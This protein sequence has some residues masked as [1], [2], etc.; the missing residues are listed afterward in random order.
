MCG[1]AGVRSPGRAVDRAVLEAMLAQMHHRGPDG[2]GLWVDGEIGLGMRRLAIVDVAGGQQP[3]ANEDGTVKVVFNG[4]I[5]N[6]EE[7]RAL[8]RARGHT[9]TSDTDGEV[10]PHLY[11]EFGPGFVERLDGIFGFAVWDAPRETLMLARDQLGVKP[12]YFH[13]SGGSVRFASELKAL[14]ADPSVPRELDLG[15]LDEYLTFRFTPAPN[16]LLRG[17]EKL[18]PA[19]YAVFRGGEATKLR[20]WDPQPVERT[21]L[22]LEEAADEFRDLL[23][24]AVRRQMMSDRPI[25]A[26]L[27]G[28]I[29]SAAVV[30]L[31]AECS[32]KVKTFTVGFEGGGDAD[33]TGL[34]RQT[35][36]LFDT[37]HHDAIVQLSDFT[38]ELAGTIEL[39]EEPVG[40]SSALGFRQVARL[41]R[42]LVPVLLSGQGADELLAG[43]WRYVGEWIAGRT[44]GVVK[45]LH[46]ERP[47]AAAAARVKTAR[48]ERGLRALRQ[49]DTLTRFL[50]IYSVFSA[51]QKHL[52]YGSELRPLLALN[53]NGSPA[54]HVERYRSRAAGR[55]SLSQMMYVDTRLWLPDDL[56]LVG[57]KMSMAE[58]VEMRVP[59]LDRALVEFTESLPSRYKLRRGV[60]KLV[61][62]EALTGLLPREIVHRKERGF[63][64][65]VA[66]WLR[67]GLSAPARE[68]LLDPDGT[69]GS[70]MDRGY[71]AQILDDHRDGR[72]DYTRQLFSLYSLE[73]WARRFTRLE[74]VA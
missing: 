29:D 64:T 53:G 72:A 36:Q 70:L 63:V 52:L 13:R 38:E 73:L 35:A 25:G 60:R 21:D 17:V 24:Q 69:C 27:S 43:Y 9:F 20:Y 67:E 32:T 71:M 55:D 45:G 54:R 4:E 61:E 14:T 3:L 51:E 40:T 8:L 62:K 2:E 58:S 66:R 22:S 30:A 16:T 12:L 34:A 68:L 7:L 50:D 47:V 44:L 42:P 46:L 19:T 74:S 56:L 57:D 11:E 31:M 65:P 1:I 41:A 18:E 26:M 10:I 49:P 6:H 39:L 15:A 28:G 33:E 59:F 37:E 23:R 48:L 5:Y